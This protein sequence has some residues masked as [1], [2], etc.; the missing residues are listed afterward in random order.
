MDRRH[1]RILERLEHG[2]EALVADVLQD[3][4]LVREDERVVL[5][6]LGIRRAEALE[7]Q[8]VADLLAPCLLWQHLRVDAEAVQR[9]LR[10][11]E[12]LVIAELVE[13]D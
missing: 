3:H 6:V 2:V 10:Q 9:L 1:A 13:Q 4:D 7:A 11:G 12:L 5:I 8:Q